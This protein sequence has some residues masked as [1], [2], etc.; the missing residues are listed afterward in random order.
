[1]WKK[2]IL[3][4][5]SFILAIILT[6]LAFNLNSL[7]GLIFKVRFNVLSEN[8]IL[9]Q[10]FIALNYVLAYI[11]LKQKSR[12]SDAFLIALLIIPL[13][14]IDIYVVIITPDFFPMR[15]PF[16]SSFILLGL[17]LAAWTIRSTRRKYRMLFSLTFFLAYCFFGHLFVLP[18][19]VNA[20]IETSEHFKITVDPNFLE[21]RVLDLDSNTHSLKKLNDKKITMIDGYFVGCPPCEQKEKAL[22]ILDSMF[23]LN[24]F[25][26]LLICDGRITSYENFKKHALKKSHN[27]LNYYYSYDSSFNHIKDASGGQSYPIELLYYNNQLFQQT[28]GFNAES[29]S[30]YINSRKQK[31]KKLLNEK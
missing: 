2:T 5:A 23:S 16:F 10:A 13:L 11:L 25:K 30:L 15:F 8:P 4:I 19:I 12:Y 21:G 6:A 20:I 24:D 9:R 27:G 14:I 26:I 28:S 31:I 29:Q 3:I 22:I 1:M 17:L 18:R 7:M